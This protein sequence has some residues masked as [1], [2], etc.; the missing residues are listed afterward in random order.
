MNIPTVTFPL[1][2]EQIQE[3]HDAVNSH[4]R[5]LQ[6][7]VALTQE[8]IK[9]IRTWCKHPNKSRWTCPDCGTRWSD[10]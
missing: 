6:T 1:S 10:D 5:A 4:L 3:K 8:L 2:Q 9:A 7:E